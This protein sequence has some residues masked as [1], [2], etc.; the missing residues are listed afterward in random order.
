ML[1]GFR[2]VLLNS[3]NDMMETWRRQSTSCPDYDHAPESLEDKQ[4]ILLN[5]AF[6]IPSLEM[7]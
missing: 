1:K 3:L 7:L 5:P 4:R 6:K 2:N